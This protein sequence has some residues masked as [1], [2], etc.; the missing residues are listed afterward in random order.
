[1]EILVLALI[2]WAVFVW[3][4]GRNRRGQQNGGSGS[5]SPSA[6]ERLPYRKKDYLFTA[7]ER[8]FF[9]VLSLVLKDEDVHIFA[10]VRMGDLLYLP[11]GTSG[12]QS[13]WNRIQSKHVDFVI[14]DKEKIQPLVV[15][16]LD[17]SSHNR[18]A[19]ARR[20][21]FIEQA[22]SDAGLTLLRFPVKRAYVTADTEAVV[23]GAL[24]RHQSE[25]VAAEP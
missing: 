1:M 15:I 7:A 25:G 3:F 22:Y 19:R 9:E 14:C 5:K 4:S 17:D 10:K 12:R 21:R 16:E 18:V 11:R 13:H 6:Y 8:S 23:K 2:A 24:G 20:D